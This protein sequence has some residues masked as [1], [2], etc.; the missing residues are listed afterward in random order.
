MRIICF[1][2]EMA[3]GYELLELSVL[4]GDGAVI[5]HKYFKPKCR[6]WS[7]KIH[8]I[9]PAMVKGL[10]S[11]SAYRS[12]IQSIMDSADYMVGCAIQNDLR[13]LRRAGIRFADHPPVIDVQ[14]M[15]WMLYC[16]DVSGEY[17]Q[18]SLE[19]ITERCCVRVNA[20]EV[21]T[22]TGDARVTL[23]C[24]DIMLDD[25]ITWYAPALRSA[26]LA[27]RVKAY[28]AALDIAKEKYMAEFARGFASL[29]RQDDGTFSFK[30]NR[31][32]CSDNPN[33]V[34]TIAVKDRRKAESDLRRMF[35]RK[36]RHG[37]GATYNLTDKDIAKFAAYSNE[38][39]PEGR[40][41]KPQ[42]PK[43]STGRRRH[44]G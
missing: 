11:V 6:S 30:F 20:D 2:T 18:T 14:P 42:S 37:S 38:Y 19:H 43:K 5:F 9:T 32:I 33:I 4:D 29:V 27:T 35:S 36:R 16:Q 26:P 41:T 31:I 40:S 22:A 8:H 12:E 24:F 39:T 17:S 28:L 13:V 25:F 34:L 10:P 1:D 3:N 44:R 23:R 15:Y 21:H 7:P